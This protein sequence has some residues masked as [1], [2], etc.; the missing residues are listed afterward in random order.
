M[1]RNAIKNWIIN[2]H[3]AYAVDLTIMTRTVRWIVVSGAQ[4][5]WAVPSKNVVYVS[6]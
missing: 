3:G 5:H 2:R 4:K 1:L 6:K